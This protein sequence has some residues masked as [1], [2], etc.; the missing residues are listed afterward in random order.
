MYAAIKETEVAEAIPSQVEVDDPQKDIPVFTRSSGRGSGARAST[1]RRTMSPPSRSLQGC[2]PIQA[3]LD[4]LC[5]GR[6]WRDCIRQSC[7][8]TLEESPPCGIE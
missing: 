2:D 1:W 8:L 6:S 7:P 5:P 4:T 3:G